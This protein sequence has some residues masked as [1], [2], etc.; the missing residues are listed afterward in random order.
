MEIRAR[1]GCW[2]RGREGT[3][4]QFLPIPLHPLPLVFMWLLISQPKVYPQSFAVSTGRRDR[5]TDKKNP[6]CAGG[7]VCVGWGGGRV[8]GRCKQCRTYNASCYFRRL[9]YL[10]YHHIWHIYMVGWACAEKNW[11]LGDGRGW[12]AR[13]LRNGLGWWGEGRNQAVH[14]QPVGFFPGGKPSG[15][16]LTPGGRFGRGKKLTITPGHG[17]SWYA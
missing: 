17:W 5:H 1:L 10:I 14:N 8:E 12:K 2:G 16:F 15:P 6:W 3:T 11:G 13:G 7:C 4:S 9:F